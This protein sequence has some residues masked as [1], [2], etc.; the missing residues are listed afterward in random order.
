[1]SVKAIAFCGV[2]A[3]VVFILMTDSSCI[4]QS[5]KYLSLKLVERYVLTVY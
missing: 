3:A 1:M 5:F 2:S 4:H